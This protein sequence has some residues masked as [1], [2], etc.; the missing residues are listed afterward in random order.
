MI[1]TVRLALE[2]PS[3]QAAALAQF[4]KRVGWDQ[5]RACAVDDVEG[6][7][8]R[9]AVETIRLALADVGFAPR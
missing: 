5:M 7:D 9:D 6:C 2:L 1:E 8:I 4:V 3:H